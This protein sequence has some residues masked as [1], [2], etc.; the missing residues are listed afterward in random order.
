MLSTPYRVVNVAG[1]PVVRYNSDYLRADDVERIDTRQNARNRSALASGKIDITTT[2]TINLSVGGSMD[3]SNNQSFNRNNSLLNA[4][5]NTEFHNSTWRTFLR[6]TQRFNSKEESAED[7]GKGG[8]KNAYYSIQLDYSRFSQKS[9]SESHGDNLFDYGY[10]GKYTT[11]RVPTYN[12]LSGK[13]TGFMDTQVHFTPSDQ[14]PD[15]AAFPEQYFSLFPEGSQFYQNFPQRS[16]ERWPVER[17]GARER[18]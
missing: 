18:V 9:E 17:P 1:N 12:Q 6:F 7:H 16:T 4:E 2:P 3:L 13:Q 14:N 15:A 11:D 5:N 10:L 8:I